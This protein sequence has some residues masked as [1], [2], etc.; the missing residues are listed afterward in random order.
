MCWSIA[1]GCQP[2]RRAPILPAVQTPPGEVTVVGIA[3]PGNPRVFELSGTCVAATVVAKPHGRALPRK[4]T[5][6]ICSRFSFMQQN[7]L[8]RWFV[9]RVAAARRRH[10][11]ASRLRVSMVLDGAAIVVLYVVLNVQTNARAL[12]AHELCI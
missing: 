5:V 1:A 3:L 11:T 7:D 8:R 12:S 4:L 9:A 2:A 6:W 10:R